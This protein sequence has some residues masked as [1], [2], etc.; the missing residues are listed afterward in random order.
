MLTHSERKL[1]KECLTS[2]HGFFS[3]Q[4]MKCER[5]KVLKIKFFRFWRIF[6]RQFPNLRPE[7]ADLVVVVVQKSLIHCFS[8]R[9]VSREPNLPLLRF[10][11]S[12]FLRFE[13]SRFVGI[14]LLLIP[15]P[16][17]V[18]IGRLRTRDNFLWCKK[19]DKLF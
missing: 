14:R 13:R 7:S 16:R 15:H 6:V 3:T 5:S 4:F 9:K 12:P 18:K 10:S 11:S 1:L 8:Q 17:N 19:S 2:P